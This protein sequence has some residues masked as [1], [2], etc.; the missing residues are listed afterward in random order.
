MF[1]TEEQLRVDYTGRNI[2][3]TD[4]LRKHTEDKLKKIQKYIDDII[5]VHVTLSVEKYRH[6]AE[7]MVKGKTT[8]LSGQSTSE[9][10]YVSI[11][12]VLDKIQRQAKK[13]KEKNWGNKRR[14]KK[15]TVQMGVFKPDAI[16][17][18]RTGRP[19]L[20]KKSKLEVKTLNIEDAVTAIEGSQDDF[21]V[22]R[23][24]ET[25]QVNVIYRR[26]DGNLGLIEP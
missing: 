22:F 8:M 24:P 18:D 16:I 14:N 10:M 6:I 11:G 19:R 17:S 23:N 7:I 15:V 4:G 21:I 5:E 9:D 3:I 13:H 2:E 1:S 25:Q 26:Q 20:L 12:N